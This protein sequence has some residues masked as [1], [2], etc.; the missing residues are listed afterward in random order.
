MTITKQDDQIFYLRRLNTVLIGILIVGLIYLF[1]LARDFLV[2]VTL[3]IF[4][5][6][7]F[8]PVIRWLALRG[9]PAWGTASAFATAILLGDYQPDIW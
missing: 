8:R 4:I 9:V 7:T 2:P 6:I 3:A 5:A 1:Y